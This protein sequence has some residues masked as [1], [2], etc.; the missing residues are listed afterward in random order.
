M[1]ARTFAIDAWAAHRALVMETAAQPS[2]VLPAYYPPQL[3]HYLRTYGQDKVLFGS[4][5]PPL[6]H[7]KCMQQV[8]E[9]GLSAEIEAGFLYGNARRP[10]RL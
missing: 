1:T 5:F 9:L 4:N 6:S 3:L 10:F 8:R 7:S 2:V